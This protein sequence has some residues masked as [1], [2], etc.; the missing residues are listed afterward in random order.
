MLTSRRTGPIL[1]LYVV[2]LI[3]QSVARVGIYERVTSL[4][5][6]GSPLGLVR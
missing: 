6:I 1:D 2:S 3:N 4:R 5:R